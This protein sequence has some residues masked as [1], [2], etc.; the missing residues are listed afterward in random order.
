MKISLFRLIGFSVFIAFYAQYSV[1]QTKPQ[2]L[3]S[4]HKK[5]KTAQSDSARLFIYID[6]YKYYFDSSI[7]DSAI[8]NLEKAASESLKTKNKI[9]LGDIYNSLGVCYRRN[10]QY[11]QSLNSYQYAI[12][13]YHR[14]KNEKEFSVRTNKAILFLIKAEYTKAMEELMICLK[15]YE[16]TNN[17]I[18]IADTYK[19]IGRV[20]SNTGDN[21]KALMYFFKAKTLLEQEKEFFSLSAIME[22]IASAYRNQL[23]FKEALIYDQ[24]QLDI[25]TKQNFSNHQATALNNMGLCYFELKDYL[26]AIEFHQKSL[27]IRKAINS[28]EGIISCLQKLCRAHIALG[29]LNEAL[30]YQQE[31]L[32]LIETS[33]KN[34]QMLSE[35]YQ[36]LYEIN[37]KKGNDKVAF[38]YFKK[39]ITLKDS[40][41]G[42]KQLQ[43]IEKIKA[44]FESEKKQNQIDALATKLKLEESER[45]KQKQLN[46]LLAFEKSNFELN[47]Q[48]LSKEKVLQ[49]LEIANQKKVLKDNSLIIK[50]KDLALSQEQT[51]KWLLLGFGI[52]MLILI[53]FVYQNYRKEKH[54]K[55]AI[56]KAKNIIEKKNI[57]FDQLIKT[58]DKLFSIIAH[59]LKSPVS[60]IHYFIQPFF[61]KHAESEEATKI[62]QK[63]AD[64]NTTMDNLLIWALSQSRG[65]SLQLRPENIKDLIDSILNTFD[66]QLNSKKISLL[67]DLKSFTANIDERKLEIVVRNLLFNA[68]KFTPEGGFIKLSLIQNQENFEIIIK[69]T[70]LGMS[71]EML[72]KALQGLFSTAGTKGEKGTGLGLLICKEFVDLHQGQ[73]YI[74]STQE[75]GTCVKIVIPYL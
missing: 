32:N 1:A 61:K 52:L 35:S 54:T 20:S 48:L 68:I 59:D 37:E 22:A 42:K 5:L 58:K 9:K 31:A 57:E 3:E 28:K 43:E 26:K 64:L 21:Q 69:D 70:G 49:Q 4:L 38:S 60:D 39:Y 65:M 34:P 63:L 11:D 14:T 66:N 46:D 6:L 24:Q 25:A 74:N 10:E 7:L 53:L 72:E 62:S 67:K 50:A 55:L 44:K 19:V 2:S 36:S 17:R 33:S 18:G 56:E 15:H 73:L 45:E 27:D 8:L 16:K 41:D 30:V 13:E 23:K 40:I 71:V 12:N 29:Q 47:N 51:I 75:S